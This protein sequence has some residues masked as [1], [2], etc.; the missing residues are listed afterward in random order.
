[1][2]AT[3]G[4]LPKSWPPTARDVLVDVAREY[5]RQIHEPFAVPDVEMEQAIERANKGLDARQREIYEEA[6]PRW[7]RRWESGELDAEME[8]A[9]R[10]TSRRMSRAARV[11]RP[12]HATKKK[13]PRQLDAE[14]ARALG[15]R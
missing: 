15:R 12:G 7:I 6:S 13:S 14:I 4:K 8:R 2:S 1:M 5:N 3:T 10:E 11:I 9:I